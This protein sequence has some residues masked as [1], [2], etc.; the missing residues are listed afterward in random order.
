MA[1]IPFFVK[2]LP[3][4]ITSANYQNAG[5]E[6]QNLT[7]FQYSG[8]VWG[9]PSITGAIAAIYGDFGPN[10]PQVNFM[11]LLGAN[12]QPGTIW[13]FQ[14][15]DAVS[16]LVAETAQYD[17][18]IFPFIDPPLA[19]GTPTRDF[20]NTFLDMGSM[21]TRRYFRFNIAGHTGS[22][23][24]PFL[25][26]GT[27]VQGS[28]YYE[29]TWSSGPADQSTIALSRNG[30]PDIAPGAMLRYLSFTLG[31]TNELE[32]EN[33]FRPFALAAGRTQPV[34]CC[35]DPS[36]GPYRQNRTY[37]GRFTDAL[38]N[39]RDGWNRFTRDYEML[40]MI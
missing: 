1:G 35:F 23:Q 24:A 40:S 30:V 22:F 21:Q 34:Y 28:R 7:E 8:L 5:Q 9:T 33:Q 14:M 12:A 10:P 37:F 17:S 6:A 39:K 19:A 15:D 38:R 29:P 31:W 4:T 20:Y 18:G 16:N 27:K 26:I 32:Y 3:F 2:P 25:V 11:A 13:R 36:Y